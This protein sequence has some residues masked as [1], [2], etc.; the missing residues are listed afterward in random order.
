M[1][2]LNVTLNSHLTGHFC[3][4]NR[5]DPNIILVMINLQMVLFVRLINQ[6]VN[7]SI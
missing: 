4:L 3:H 7:Q 6:S 5:T 1:E 2:T